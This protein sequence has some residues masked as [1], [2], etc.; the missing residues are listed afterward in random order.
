MSQIDYVRREEHF[1]AVE[2]M[3]RRRRVPWDRR[4]RVDRRKADPRSLVGAGNPRSHRHRRQHS[5]LVATQPL[6]VSLDDSTSF[7]H[8]HAQAADDRVQPKGGAPQ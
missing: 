6:L 8:N 2:S 5:H 1:A 4:C 3:A 7:V